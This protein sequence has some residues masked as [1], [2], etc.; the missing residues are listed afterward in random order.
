MGKYGNLGWKFNL[1]NEE[2]IISK[3]KFNKKSLKIISEG[4]FAFFK[5]L[6]LNIYRLKTTQKFLNITLNMKSNNALIIF[7]IFVLTSCQT[8]KTILNV[9][10]YESYVKSLESS[11][12]SKSSM[13][14]KWISSG[15]N[16]LLNPTENIKFPFKSE[17]FFREIAPNAISYK[18]RYEEY[19]KLTFK[20]TSKGKDNNGVYVDIFEDNPNK[21]RVKNFY[22]KDTIFVYENGSSQN[23]ILRIQPQLLVNQYVTL[24]IIEN[25]KLAFPVKNGSNKDI[26]SFWGVDRDGGVRK[27]EGVDIFNK[28]GTPILA[29]EDGTIARVETNNLGGKVVWQRLGLFGQSIYYAHLDSQAV[30][31]GQVVKKG[32][33][34]GF[35]G[36]TGNAKYTPSHLHFGIYTGSG[37]IDPLLYIQ[38]RDTIPGK[39]KLSE[40][41]LGNEVIL[42]TENGQMPIN[43]L[44]VSS[45]AINY[46]D[47]LGNVQS[48]NQLNIN[49]NIKAKFK[50]NPYTLNITDEP[51][52]EGIPIAK[53]NANEKFKILGYIDNYLYLE[54]NEVKG[55]VLKE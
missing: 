50:P 6:K 36:N 35:M 54:Q 29:V 11:G 24:E 30:S 18:F 45:V 41:Y 31:T 55:W 34:V 15:E 42:K 16:A 47:Y 32:D 12:I 48:V 49:G 51:I 25:P 33:I 43:L 3:R 7:V 28:K 2:K 53:F 23:L 37:A 1:I 52:S 40:K 8:L 17:I 26:Q 4:L 44:S 5:K 46:A 39:L 19:A 14:K 10:P 13:G 27:H 22:V 21:S 38:K 20:I 9:S